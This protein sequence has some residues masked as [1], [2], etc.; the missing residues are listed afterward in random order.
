[1]K[2]ECAYTRAKLPRYLTGHL[3]K[4][5]ASR[6]ERHLAACPVCSSEYDALRR[7]RETEHFLRD[8][9]AEGGIAA[10]TRAVA[11]A[12]LKLFYRPLWVILILI[13]VIALQRYVLT[14]LLHDPDL[15]KLEAGSSSVTTAPAATIHA[16]PTTTT[17][18][19]P[20][21]QAGRKEPSSATDPL[22]VTIIVNKEQEKESIRRINEAM[23]E[24]ALLRTMRF[25][26]KVREVAGNLTAD[27]LYTFFGRI[28]DAAKVA[29]KASRMKSAGAELVPV[30][31]QLQV[32]T[33]PGLQDSPK[34]AGTSAEKRPVEKTAEKP[35]ENPERTTV[36]NTGEPRTAP[37]SSTP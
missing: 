37:S 12:I 34:P 16:A 24:H 27:E 2:E 14:P 11:S 35:A 17:A 5:Q 36:T 25:S 13:S 32:R 8:L 10:T 4:L 3:F 18:A 29:Y 21:V 9:E 6:V 19:V 20:A 1:M 33:M 23:K 31:L 28:R 26:D 30:V 15:E 7:I 22:V